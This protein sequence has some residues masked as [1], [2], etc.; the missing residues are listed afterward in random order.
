MSQVR[1]YHQK[2]E[3]SPADRQKLNLSKAE[4]VGLTM[5]DINCPL[6]GYLVEKVFSDIS[7]HKMVYCKKCKAEY[8]V[9]LGYF[10]KKK[11]RWNTSITHPHRERLHR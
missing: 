5:R 9:N 6:C 3:V 4:T 1:A 8:P 11:K 2:T 10:R 7:G